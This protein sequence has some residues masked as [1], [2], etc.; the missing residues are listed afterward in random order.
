VVLL[1]DGRNDDGQPSDDQRQLTDLLAHLRVGSEGAATRPVRVFT[2]GY[3][4]DADF[5]VLR[6][7]AEATN[8]RDYRA[9]NPRTIDEVFTNVISNF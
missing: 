4:S 2:I 7:V 8:A 6:Q 3:G 1:T 9:D 5:D